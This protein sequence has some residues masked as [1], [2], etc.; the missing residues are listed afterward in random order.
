MKKKSNERRVNLVTVPSFLFNQLDDDDV[1][2][3]ASIQVAYYN[4]GVIELS[5]NGNGILLDENSVKPLMDAI[6][7][8]LEQVNIYR[9]KD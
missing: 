6:L 5:Q 7:Y 2:T 1:I 9:N 3:E 8:N 4:G